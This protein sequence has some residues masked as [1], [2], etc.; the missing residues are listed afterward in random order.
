MHT[1]AQTTKKQ[2]HVHMSGVPPQLPWH[3]PEY[4]SLNRKL[5]TVFPG[6]FR[7]LDLQENPQLLF[8]TVTFFTTVP[9]VAPYERC[10]QDRDQIPN[11]SRL[12][13]NTVANTYIYIKRQT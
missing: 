2:R 6:I 1:F 5:L 8:Q 3:S 10:K 11:Y 12:I 13:Q 4:F 7:I 9:I